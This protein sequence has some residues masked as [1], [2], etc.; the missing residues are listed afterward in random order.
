MAWET[1]RRGGR[2]YTRSRKIGGRVVREYVGS[3]WRG[4]W[5]PSMTSASA[6]NAPL[7]WRPGVRNASRW[8]QPR[9]P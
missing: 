1:R 6:S 5:L 8:R 7:L 3:G 2:Y 4:N 9:R